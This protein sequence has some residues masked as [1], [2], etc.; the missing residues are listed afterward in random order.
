MGAIWNLWALAFYVVPQYINFELTMHATSLGLYLRS[1]RLGR[2][3]SKVKN[4]F[5]KLTTRPT[6]D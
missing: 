4:S 3:F 1:E 5:Q 6:V 2:F